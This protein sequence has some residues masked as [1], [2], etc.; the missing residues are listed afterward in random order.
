MKAATPKSK[1]RQLGD[2]ENEAD[3]SGND[4]EIH[5]AENAADTDHANIGTV[6]FPSTPAVRIELE[7]LIGN[8]EDIFNRPA[9]L[10]TPVDH[11]HWHNGPNSSDVASAAQTTQRS[12]KRARSSSPASSQLERSAH[13]DTQDDPAAAN[14][15]RDS[16]HTPD[17]D[18][19]QDLWRRYMNA[20]GSR[21]AADDVLPT[22]TRLPPSSPTTPGT[23]T[24]DSGLRR[25]VSCGVEWPT[26]KS[27]RRKLDIA[28]SHNRT[29]NI[30]AASRRDI[31]AREV[32]KTSRVSLLVEK[33]QESLAR[34]ARASDE[35]SS[36]SPLP[37]RHSQMPLSQGS[38][39]L[40]PSK[41]R[42]SP[43]QSGPHLSASHR[44][45]RS[46]EM[47][48]PVPDDFEDDGLDLEFFEE[49]E[50]G[51]SQVAVSQKPAII[52]RDFAESRPDPRGLSQQR[53]DQH[54]PR[55][56]R[57][58]AS[59]VKAPLVASNQARSTEFDLF[60][61]DDDDI[62][63]TEMA[64]LVAKVDSQGR[65]NA[66]TSNDIEPIMPQLSTISELDGS[67]DDANDDDLLLQVADDVDHGKT[68]FGPISQVRPS[69]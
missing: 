22:M 41:Q 54:K 3:D 2:K 26:S 33:I 55:S 65:G 32:S 49:V 48:E 16:L 28:N 56:Q 4:Q 37:G 59:P 29:K 45:L 5:G 19:T 15:P 39:I 58:P 44:H 30:F 53:Q 10:G 63:T 64:S 67:F 9:P 18:P 43:D 38:L 1:S 69:R 17:H 42:E 23:S 20:N 31:L 36:S 46:A 14:R 50:K 51:M 68:G 57:E 27:K 40:S 25:T 8:T 13:F 47:S 11:V 6:A 7:D 60:D 62:F 52:V 12:R 34:Q 24:K 61:D 35:P 21:H 66:T